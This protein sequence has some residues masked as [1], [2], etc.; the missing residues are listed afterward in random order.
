M[1]AK[2]YVVSYGNDE[3]VLKLTVVIVTQLHE[4]TK[5]YWT[6]YTLKGWICYV[7]YIS[8]NLQVKNK[9]DLKDSLEPYL[10]S[11]WM[12][13]QRLQFRDLKK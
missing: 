2:E 7:N 8:D 3:H 13:G 4:H 1:T 10:K 6:V 11:S 5:N 12:L 9:G